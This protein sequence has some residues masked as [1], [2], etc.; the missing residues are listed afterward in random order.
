[1]VVILDFLQDYY[2]SYKIAQ[3]FYNDQVFAVQLSL[4]YF[5]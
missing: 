1:M 4:A 3:Q 5:Q 2:E